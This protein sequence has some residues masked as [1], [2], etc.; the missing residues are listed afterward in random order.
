MWKNHLR[1]SELPWLRDHQIQGD[2]VFP[3]AGM[4]CAVVE[5]A[6]QLVN[7]NDPSESIKGFELRDVCINRPLVFPELDTGVETLLHLKRRK[8]GMGTG[9]GVWHEFAFYSCHENEAVEHA[10]GL[11]EIQYAPRASEVD[12]GK[13]RLEEVLARQ[14][15]WK[16][17]QAICSDVVPS[18]AHYDFWRS[19]G[20]SFG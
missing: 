13:E 11:V 17:L 20:L 3:A 12:G 1:I 8:L 2:V 15:K 18:P 5:A 19:Q 6:R 7:A 16:S 10:C 4:I 9:A 14:Q